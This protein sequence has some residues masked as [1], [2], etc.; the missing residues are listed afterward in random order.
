LRQ[1]GD[2]DQPVNL[3]VR[4]LR[5]LVVS[6]RVRIRPEYAWDRV[7]ASL[8]QR[9]LE[10]FGFDRRE[11][12]QDVTSSEV[13]A[14]IQAAPGVEYADLGSVMD[15]RGLGWI[16]GEQFARLEGENPPDSLI[17]WV[18]DTPPGDARVVAEIARPK[19][20][21]RNDSPILPAQLV[22]LSPDVPATLILTEIK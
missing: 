16:D 5:L 22:T 12:G 1:N 9:M 3:D 14:V 17:Q 6:A 18:P 2:A 20:P 21:T 15:N 13:L 4:D 7:E 19:D 8:R 11:L 10:H